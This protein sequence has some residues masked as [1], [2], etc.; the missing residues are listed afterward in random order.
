[1]TLEQ[2]KNEMDAA[3]NEMDAAYIAWDAARTAYY[4]KL[5]EKDND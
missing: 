4:N 5:K 1:M 3:F 2:L